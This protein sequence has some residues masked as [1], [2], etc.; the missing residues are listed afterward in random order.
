MAINSQCDKV[1]TKDPLHYITPHP[2]LSETL[3]KM[4]S[5][6]TN[7]EDRRRRVDLQW[8]SHHI[9]KLATVVVSK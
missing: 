2:V 1:P 9:G 8:I 6:N 5:E 4:V 3:F 7:S